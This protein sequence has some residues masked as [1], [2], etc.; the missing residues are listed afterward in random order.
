M[1]QTA[2]LQ[3]L[4][5]RL[6]HIDSEIIAIRRELL[7]FPRDAPE[8]ATPKS[9]GSQKWVNKAD[10]RREIQ[11]F[12]ASLGVSGSPIGAEKLQKQMAQAN[13]TRNEVSQSLIAEREG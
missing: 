12:L 8:A 6:N 7:E 11:V 1:S 9:E 5:T 10:L 3:R 4:T 13:L 2:T